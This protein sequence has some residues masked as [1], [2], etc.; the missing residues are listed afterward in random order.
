MFRIHL[1]LVIIF[2]VVVSSAISQE[3]PTAYESSCTSAPSS[4]TQFDFDLTDSLFAD[5]LADHRVLFRDQPGT[6]WDYAPVYFSYQTCGAFTFSGQASYVPPSGMLE[7]YFR[8]ENDTAVVSQS[9]KNSADIFPAPD[10]LM[11]DMG[12]D[13][14]GDAVGAAG[15]WLDVT[16]LYAGYSDAKLYVSLQNN[17]GGFPTNQGLF[18]YFLYTVGIVDPN[19]TDSVAYVLVYA[20]VPALFSPGLY[21][22]DASDSS[23]TQIGS[24]TTN[25]SGNRLNMSCNI[26]DLTAQPSWS[27]WPP[28]AGYIGIAPVTATANFTNLSTNDFGKTG[29]FIPASHLLDF[30]AANNA[31]S[32]SGENVSLI[33]EDTINAEITYTDIDGHLPTIR[34]LILEGVEYPMFACEKSYETGALFEQSL[35]VTESGWYHYYFEF[36]D[37]VETVTTAVDSIQVEII[38]YVCGDANGDESV[39]VSDAV[40]IINYIFLGTAEPDPYE[41]ADAN[42]DGSVNVSD[43]VWI[44]NYIFLETNA[45]C[46]SDGDGNPDC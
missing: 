45:P 34:N 29:V 14:A 33:G 41:S 43:S 32:L 15:S 6:T 1:I 21:I 31:P 11:A 7:W 5:T 38:T 4:I 20:S 40:Y 8:S 23:F 42:C 26:S 27:D 46:D 36:S 19:T 25:I 44:I 28:P 9:P 22:L 2:A 18:T 37:G 30:N 10:Y 16:H 17:G 35:N 24:I 12:A 39:N 3:F 13:P